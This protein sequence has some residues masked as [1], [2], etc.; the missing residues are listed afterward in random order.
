MMKKQPEPQNLAMCDE[1]ATAWER[2]FHV[3]PADL[4]NAIETHLNRRITYAR[5]HV[6]I[7]APGET[8]AEPGFVHEFMLGEPNEDDATY[9]EFFGDDDP[10]I[11]NVLHAAGVIDEFTRVI[12]AEIEGSRTGLR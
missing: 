1:D 9:N 3:S 5:L 2:F 7:C 11:T 8:E 4:R 12:V 10:T 6:E